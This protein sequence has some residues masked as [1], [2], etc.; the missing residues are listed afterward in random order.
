MESKLADEIYNSAITVFGDDKVDLTTVVR[1]CV[2]LMQL[3]EKYRELSGSQK[4]DLVLLTLRRIIKEKVV[5]QDLEDSLLALLDLTIPPLI[6][7]IVSVD[8]KQLVIDARNWLTKVS[9]CCK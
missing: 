7:I 4:K 1:C 2:L 8:R 3:V 5:D 6:D 9:K